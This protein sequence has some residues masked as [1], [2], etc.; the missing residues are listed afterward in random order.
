MKRLP[1]ALVL[2]VLAVPARA[3]TSAQVAA[4]LRASPVYQ[5]TGLD[6][7]DVATLTSELAGTDPQVYV[8]VLPASAAA[9]PADARKRA[10][11]IGDAL[12]SSSA[13]VL[14][15]TE[16]RHFG[17]GQGGA[18]AARGVDSGEALKKEVEGLRA[19]TKADLTLLVT[20]FAERVANQTASGAV[21]DGSPVDT[22]GGSGTAWLV[23]GL[24]VTGAAALLVAVRAGRR[25]APQGE[26]ELGTDILG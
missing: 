21:A 6:L 10:V 11:E 19:F 20:S 26:E 7:V 4:A 22:G 9:S 2:L 1:L 5:S 25:R 16:N 23:V 13:V 24:L 12:A 8:A 15:I 17:S 3:D 14:V 18:A